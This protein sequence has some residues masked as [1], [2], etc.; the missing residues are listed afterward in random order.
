MQNKVCAASFQLALDFFSLL[1]PF[2]LFL[3]TGISKEVFVTRAD[4]DEAYLR[5]VKTALDQ[6]LR[7]FKPDILYY[8]A[9][10]GS[11]F[12]LHLSFFILFSLHL[13]SLCS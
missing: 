9:G 6:A 11:L 8:N 10:T 2:F 1:S 13:S 12:S 3:S 4:N 7:K 5:K